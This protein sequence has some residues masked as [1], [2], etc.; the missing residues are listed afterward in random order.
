MVAVSV[1]SKFVS[2]LDRTSVYSHFCSAKDGGC[3]I[4]A[5][6]GRHRR[7]VKSST[8]YLNTVVC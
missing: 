2:N 1:L 4:L 3:A 8:N 5:P 7:K 6:R